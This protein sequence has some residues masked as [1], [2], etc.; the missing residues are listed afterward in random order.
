MPDDRLANTLPG[1]LEAMG[2]DARL[3]RS[4]QETPTVERAAVALGVPASAIV[5][6]IVFEHKHDSSRVCLAIVGGD[7]RV[8]RAKVADAL[9][10]SQLRL[11]APSTI[12]RAT[13]YRAGGVPPVGHRTRI[14]VVIDRRVLEQ[15]VVYGGGGDEWHMV[16]ISPRDIQRLT[17]AAVADVVEDPEDRRAPGGAAT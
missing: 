3:I 2:V 7:A 1:Y 8:S 12:L 9:G 16:R 10:L 4:D 6:S 13:G 17:G 14:P 15:D 11:A 5:K